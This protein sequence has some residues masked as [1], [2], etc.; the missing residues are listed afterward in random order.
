VLFLG[1]QTKKRRKWLKGFKFTFTIIT[2]KNTHMDK[3]CTLTTGFYYF[4]LLSGAIVKQH[5][6][7]QHSL[8][9]CKTPF[10]AAAISKSTVMW[11]HP[12]NDTDENWCISAFV[13][14]LLGH[15]FVDV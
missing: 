5:I 13:Q 11:P 2:L 12:E 10:C 9:L 6:I 4:N 8:E 15:F 1:L 14:I 3:G 7:I